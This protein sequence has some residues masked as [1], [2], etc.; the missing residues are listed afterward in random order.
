MNGKNIQSILDIS[1][2][3][4]SGKRLLMLFM[5][6]NKPMGY[7]SIV[8]SF[9]EVEIPI[10]SSEIYKHLNHLMGQGFIAKTTKFYVLTLKGF[11]AVENTMDIIETPATTPEV[12]LSF[13]RVQDD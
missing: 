9:E 7:T 13:R 6:K 4:S 2:T 3:F 12:R 11:R 10:G 8:K 1:Q 5:L